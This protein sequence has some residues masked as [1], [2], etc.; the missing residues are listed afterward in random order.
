[1]IW[2]IMVKRIDLGSTIEPGLLFCYKNMKKV[3]NVFPSCT[4]IW[5]KEVNGHGI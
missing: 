2:T 1:M 5:Q 3:C 4:L